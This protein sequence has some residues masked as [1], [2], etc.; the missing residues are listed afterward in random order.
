MQEE[1]LRQVT[2]LT[3]IENVDG[4]DVEFSAQV[5]TLPQA[6]IDGDYKITLSLRRSNDF[7][8]VAQGV[9]IQLLSRAVELAESELDE[10]F[11]GQGGRQGDLFAQDAQPG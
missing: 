10:Y 1:L 11:A 5:T 8:A 3:H 4:T 7:D 6:R 2:K 9:V